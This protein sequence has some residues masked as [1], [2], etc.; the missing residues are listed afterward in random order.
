M[1]RIIAIF[2][3]L[4]I[5][6][7]L[8][9][10]TYSYN[11]MSVEDSSIYKYYLWILVVT[12][13]LL[14]FY[15]VVRK[16]WFKNKALRVYSIFVFYVFVLSFIHSLDGISP[17]IQWPWLLHIV[18]PLLCGALSYIIIEERI[19]SFEKTVNLS[20][21]LWILFVIIFLSGWTSINSVFNFN[22]RG[23]NNIYYV[24]LA[25]PFC[26]CSESKWIRFVTIVITGI[27][28]VISLKR[29]AILGFAVMTF[30]YYFLIIEKKGIYKAVTLISI[31]VVVFLSY[32]YLD[33]QSGNYVSS[34]FELQ[35]SGDDSREDIYL[36][37]ID[38]LQ[39]S[40]IFD[41]IVGHGSSSVKDITEHELSAHN[42]FLEIIYDYGIIALVIWALFL[43]CVLREGFKKKKTKGS[44]GAILMSSLGLVFVL[45]MF[46][47]FFIMSYSCIIM[48]CWGAILSKYSYLPVVKQD[49]KHI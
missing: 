3:L 4:C 27:L 23:M 17:T 37:I 13:P 21:G 9:I 12:T 35:N 1:K 31:G 33:N 18:Y 16:H 42:D 41:L 43:L 14:T 39:K 49:K 48:I 5:S 38:A 8:L 11:Q 10:D 20:L 46:S 6:I 47:H 26:Q 15:L 29:G 25:L 24:L 7:A 22:A 34:R 2:F 19:Y 30:L 32:Q 28:C 36:T 40:S 45:C 44:G